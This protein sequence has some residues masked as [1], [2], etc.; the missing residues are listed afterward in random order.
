VASKVA[1][2]ESESA[3]STRSHDESHDGQS[4][5][6]NYVEFLNH[7][8]DRVDRDEDKVYMKDA[9]ETITLR[10]VLKRRTPP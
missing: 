9:P 6:Q 4:L 10:S 2:F 3:G 7:D 8:Q 5:N 1:L